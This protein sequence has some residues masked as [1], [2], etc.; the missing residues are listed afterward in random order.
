MTACARWQVDPAGRENPEDVTMGE[1]GDTTACF[2]NPVDHPINPGRNLVRRFP[3]RTAIPEDHPSR[4]LPV[5]LGRCQPLIGA[6][7]PL[8]EIGVDLHPFANTG[9]FT[10]LKC[11]LKGTG[12]N[13]GEVLTCEGGPETLGRPT[14]VVGERDVGAAC[15]LTGETPLRLAMANQKGLSEAGGG[16][17]GRNA[18]HRQGTTHTCRSSCG[19]KVKE[20]GCGDPGHPKPDR[21]DRHACLRPTQRDTMMAMNEDLLNSSMTFRQS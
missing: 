21:Q 5:D 7:I 3:A 6:V 13:Q 11:A 18:G 15:V 16:W 8:S 1:E 9:Q 14:A 19:R 17:A 4:S 20:Q 10:G 12:E 2:A